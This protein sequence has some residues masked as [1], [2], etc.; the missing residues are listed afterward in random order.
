MDNRRR[1]RA[2]NPSKVVWRGGCLL[3]RRHSTPQGG[4]RA[5]FRHVVGAFVG[6][7]LRPPTHQPV[8]RALKHAAAPGRS[9]SA[10]SSAMRSEMGCCASPWAFGC[11]L[12]RR[13]LNDALV[14]RRMRRHLASV[15]RLQKRRHVSM[16]SVG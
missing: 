11:G 14:Q 16:R 9:N 3:A 7:R 5:V 1:N 13:Q 15:L 2:P 4:H 6:H 8:N 12:L 10:G